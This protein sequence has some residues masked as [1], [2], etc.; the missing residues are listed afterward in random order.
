MPD[1]TIV[2]PRGLEVWRVGYKPEPWAWVDWRWATDGRFGNRWDDRDGNF[3][4]IYAGSTLLAC[5]LELLADFRPDPLIAS[6]LDDVREDDE[7]DAMY[8]TSK[9]GEL[10][11]T[12]L[13][14]RAAGYGRLSGRFCSITTAESIATL[15]PQFVSLAL[16]LGLKDF[17]AAALKDGRARHLTRSLTTYLHDRIDLGLH[18]INFASRH[19]DD[20]ELWAIFERPED[21][22]VTPQ[23]SSVEQFDLTQDH[24]D[25]VKALEVLGLRWRFGA[26]TPRRPDSS[27]NSPS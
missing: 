27:A 25:V 23:V 20:L 16:H 21:P 7:D 1:L 18:G 14:S 4:T 2:E 5:L 11:P 15:H 13:D 12:W 26:T 9:A 10:D 17:D 24:P 6:D 8:P 22:S 3:R 19:G